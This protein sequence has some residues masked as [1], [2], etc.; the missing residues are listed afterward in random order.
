LHGFSLVALMI[1]PLERPILPER[2][3]LGL[4]IRPAQMADIDPMLNLQAEAFAD[5]FMAA[6][7]R[8]GAERGLAALSRTHH[9]QG[10]G[11]LQG[12]HVALVQERIV[13][14]ITMRTVEMRIDDGGL[15]EQAFL[16]ELG[17]W[18]TIRAMRAFSQLEHYIGRDE[19][20]ITDVAVVPDLRR[21]GI[22]QAMLRYIITLARET[23]KG[24]LG[25]YVSASNKNAITL[26]Y[27]L[28]FREQLVRRS[29]WNAL[30]L[31][32]RRWM[33][34]TYTIL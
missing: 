28:G 30:F 6:F 20:Y 5:K 13:G 17:T 7:G 2:T 31:G 1:V 16:R 27:N 14:T 25:L 34:M 9:L 8:H 18:G 33:Y 15:V 26:Y 19:G 11:S 22:A 4:M 12:M 3:E 21:Q 10:P 29:W 32:E 23:G 24:R